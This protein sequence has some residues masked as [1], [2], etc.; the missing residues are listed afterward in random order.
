MYVAMFHCRK[1]YLGSSWGKHLETNQGHKF[2]FSNDKL[3]ILKHICFGP[4]G[5][6]YKDIK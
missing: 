2:L 4:N 6:Q 5:I 3:H 1:G